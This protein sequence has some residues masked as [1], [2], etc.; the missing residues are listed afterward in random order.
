MQGRVVVTGV[1][2]LSTLG[3]S[4][5]T[6]HHA[7]CMGQYSLGPIGL[8]RTDCS[9]AQA[10]ELTDFDPQARLGKKSTRLRSDLQPC[11]R[12][13]QNRS[14]QQRLVRG[15]AARAGCRTH[16]RHHVLQCAHDCRV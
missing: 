5:L 6:L 9:T 10:P 13:G 1:G 15:D 14:G 12:V 11:H 8:F 2:V 7:L 4:P 16:P 3:D